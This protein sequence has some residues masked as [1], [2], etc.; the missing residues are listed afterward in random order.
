MPYRRYYY[1]WQQILHQTAM[2]CTQ[3]CLHRVVVVSRS[4]FVLRL[5]ASSISLQV[6]VFCNLWLEEAIE[7]QNV[8]RHAGRKMYMGWG[9]DFRSAAGRPPLKKDASG[10]F[11]LSARGPGRLVPA[12]SMAT[13]R[14][15]VIGAL[16][17][18]CS[19]S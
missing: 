6:A 17:K 13:G 1:L 11:A 8:T 9:F 10:A 3:A 12:C 2:S 19:D 4:T 5:D 15:D 18:R 7:V 14:H 16:E